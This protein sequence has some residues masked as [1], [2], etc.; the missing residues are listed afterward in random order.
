L[1]QTGLYR[2]LVYVIPELA[3][4]ETLT[5]EYAAFSRSA[6]G[7]S[8]TLGGLLAAGIWLIG[9][10]ADPPLPARAALVLALPAWMAAKTWLRHHYYQRHGEA[11]E[12]LPPA[13]I[14]IEHFAQGCVG[15]VAAVLLAICLYLAVA[16]PAKMDGV[17]LLNRLALVA[18]PLI[19]VV[20]ARRI[21]TPFEAMVAV[22]L[23]VQTVM[24]STGT[25]VP[26]QRQNFTLAASLFLVA[27]GLWEHF[28]FRS[29]EAQ[30]AALRGAR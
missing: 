17:P 7:L 3:R 30:L 24:L 16:G 29:V 26:W 25:P 22:N 11:R 19:A 9:A 13:A 5:R 1:T 28:R 12:S 27:I 6:S 8:N 15:G 14:G 23:L 10:Y 21:N 20:L 2:K 4:L 18:G